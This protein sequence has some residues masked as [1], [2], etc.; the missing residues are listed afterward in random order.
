VIIVNETYPAACLS[1]R[2]LVD[3]DQPYYQIKGLEAPKV[4]TT[5]EQPLSEASEKSLQLKPA[6]KDDIVVEPETPSRT[7]ESGSVD[8]VPHEEARPVFNLANNVGKE[9]A[10]NHVDEY[11][12]DLADMILVAKTTEHLVSGFL[13]FQY[14]ALIGM[15]P[16]DSEDEDLGYLNSSRSSN[17][18]SSERENREGVS[19]RHTPGANA[20]QQKF[21]CMQSNDGNKQEDNPNPNAKT[22]EILQEIA[23]YYD[24]TQDRWRTL[25][26]RKVITTLRKQTLHITTK[27][28][29][30]RLPFIG[31]RLAAKIEEIVWTNKLRRLENTKLEP[32]AHA[33]QT[34]LNVYGIGF[35][36]AS[37]FVQA[38]FK[39]L[40]DLL[41][42]ANLTDN[43]RVGIAHYTDFL[44]RIPRAEVEKLGAVVERALHHIDAAIQI[45]I[46]GSYRRGAKDSGDIDLIITKPGAST[47]Y[48]K[49]IV[50]D[51][52][53]P[54]LAKQGFLTACL[55]ATSKDT[56]T[57]WHGACQLPSQTLSHLNGHEESVPHRPWRRI[58]L[59]LV[60]WDEIG[61]AMIYFTGND[62]FNRSI[63]LLARKKGMR[64][65][66]KGLYVDVMRDSAQGKVT[67]GNKVEGANERKIF[68]RLGVP[69]R[70]PWE[71][72]C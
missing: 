50:V 5:S 14:Q 2:C 67:E 38:G 51:T 40:D 15:Q 13:A 63:R 35:Q 8:D 48:L 10:R 18:G 20:W 24:S 61:A 49:T 41:A 29:A 46:G 4:H 37:K 58:D 26:Y 62:I 3:A 54:R 72:I 65:N 57:K 34:F 30:E 32:D 45:T 21:S 11:D 71:R 68:E 69:W 59:L 44:T 33:F 28:E 1:H 47:A 53:V 17:L 70:E 36:Q 12:D 64:L 60:P 25:A 42:N 16:L 52:L 9:M 22:I 39:T 56:G 19:D 23:T 31:A 55:A 66:Q 27:E 6:R 43:Q 7:E